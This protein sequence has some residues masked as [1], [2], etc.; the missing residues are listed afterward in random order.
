MDT[1]NRDP[2]RKIMGRSTHGHRKQGPKEENNEQFYT[3]TQ[4][5]GTQRGK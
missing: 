5:T 1:G 2:K 3:W 4:E